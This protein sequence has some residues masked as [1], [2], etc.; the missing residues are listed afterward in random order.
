MSIDLCS[1]RP[2]A[3]A[4]ATPLSSRLLASML[5]SS[6]LPALI[7]THVLAHGPLDANHQHGALHQQ[8]ASGVVYEDLNNNRRR[9]PGE[10]GL[11]GIRVSNGEAIVLTD[12]TGKYTVPVDDDE[13]IFVIKPRDWVTPLNDDNLP[14]FHYIHKPAGSPVAVQICRCGADGTSCPSRSIFRC[15]VASNPTRSR[16]CCLGIRNHA[17]STEV[18]YIAHDVVEQIICRACPRRCLWGDPRRHCLR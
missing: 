16:R 9:D 7:A 18:E 11:P 3:R 13:I 15:V 8:T 12:E 10:P 17:T 2:I 6:M 14:Q 1:C 5:L 4:V